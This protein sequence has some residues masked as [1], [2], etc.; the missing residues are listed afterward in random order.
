MS[1]QAYDWAP[2]GSYILYTEE[3][4]YIAVSIWEY[5]DENRRFPDYEI[6]AYKGYCGTI[7]EFRQWRG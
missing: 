2:E 7:T 5:D 6:V 1:A 3:T 4:G